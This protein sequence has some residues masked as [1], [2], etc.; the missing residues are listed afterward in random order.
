MILHAKNKERPLSLSV[1][2]NCITLSIEYE[3]YTDVFSYDFE[4]RPWTFMIN[5]VSYRRGLDGKTVAKWIEKD[6]LRNRR[7][8]T[9]QE[10]D[11]MAEKARVLAADLLQGIQTGLVCFDSVLPAEGLRGLE[12]AGVFDC[13]KRILERTRYGQIYLPVGILP[14]DHYGAVVLQATLGCSFNTCTFCSFYKDRPFRIKKADEFEQHCQDVKGLLG[15]GLSLR[16]TLFLGDANALVVPMKRL[17]PLLEISHKYFDL[18]ELGGVFAFLDGV[19]GERKTRA[20]FRLLA[21][22]GLKRVYIG[23]ESGSARLL[24]F[25]RKPSSPTDVLQLVKVIKSSGIS[26]GVIVL[27]GAGG[28][29]YQDEHIRQTTSI[30]NKMHLGMDDILYFSELIE[31]EGM[32]YVKDAYD[33]Q[34]MPLTS[35]ERVQQAEMIER[36]LSFSARQGVPHISRYDIREFVY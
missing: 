32:D 22:L 8:L 15:E 4:G 30:L 11:G 26:V 5:G 31:S 33:H 23:L 14:P 27:L 12:T 28:K 16:R 18:E 13:T 20:D 19:G 1:K 3:N 34:L 35:E 6:G 17:V 7:W 25:L 36:G 24:R 29:T 2:P 10:A 9:E 21:K